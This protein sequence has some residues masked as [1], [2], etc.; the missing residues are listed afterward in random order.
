MSSLSHNSVL[1]IYK[2]LVNIFKVIIL[3]SNYLSVC[4]RPY[5]I[6]VFLREALVDLGVDHIDPLLLFHPSHVIYMERPSIINCGF[7]WGLFA[8]EN[9]YI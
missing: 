4:T 8:N 5:F 6:H 2:S 9:F 3:L 1:V 7:V